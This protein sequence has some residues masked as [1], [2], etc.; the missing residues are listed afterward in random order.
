VGNNETTGGAADVPQ[1]SAV[2]SDRYA[3]RASA[4][5]SGWADEATMAMPISEIFREDDE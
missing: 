5:G 3:G 2:D 1:P 4:P